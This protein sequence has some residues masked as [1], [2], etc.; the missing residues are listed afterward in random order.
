MQQRHGHVTLSGC[1][2]VL[3]AVLCGTLASK[4]TLERGMGRKSFPDYSV[5]GRR[6]AGECLA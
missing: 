2:K 5:H 6:A 1:C 4:L 3:A